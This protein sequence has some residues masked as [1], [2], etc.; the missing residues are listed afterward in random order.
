MEHGYLR[1]PPP[2]PI[3]LTHRPTAPHE[4]GRFITWLQRFKLIQTQRHHAKHHQGKKNSHYCSI[5][6]F[7]NLIL[8]ES[9]FWNTL[10]RFNARMFSLQRKPG[11]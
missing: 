5:T 4:N 7:L 2:I 9:E 1:L 8:E 3:K 10:E 6:N 11:P